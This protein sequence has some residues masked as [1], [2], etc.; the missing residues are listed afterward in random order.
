MGVGEA[1]KNLIEFDKTNIDTKKTLVRN[2]AEELDKA[3]IRKDARTLNQLVLLGLP[4]DI[5]SISMLIKYLIRKNKISIDPNWITLNLLQKHKTN[6]GPE[7]KTEAPVIRL[8]DN[9]IKEHADELQERIKEQTR[10]PA[11]DIKIKIKKETIDLQGWKSSISLEL[12]ELA[13]KIDED[14]TVDKELEE[15]IAARLKMVRDGRFATTWSRY[16][17]TIAAVETT[18]S[19]THA[20]AEEQRPLTRV[21]IVKN[22]GG[23]RECFCS[24][25]PKDCN[26]HCHR[27]TQKMTTKGLKWAIKHNKRLGEFDEKMKRIANTDHDDVCPFIK[28][29]FT[30]VNIDKH[31]NHSNKMDILTNHIEKDQC[32]RCEEFLD[33]HPGFFTVNTK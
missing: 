4:N 24:G 27:T 17:A 10:G 7:L 18:K 33:S 15:E 14:E 5:S 2:L 30:N 25:A 1:I 11:Q 26:C 9:Y 12:V 6:K 31:M 23:C 3:I 29:L 28:S 20:I 32:I 22:E 19:L 13:K 16:E 8:S 21:E